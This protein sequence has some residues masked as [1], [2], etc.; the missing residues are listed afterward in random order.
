V[1]L[2]IIFSVPPPNGDHHLQGEA[3]KDRPR[4]T[5]GVKCRAN[6]I[7]AELLPPRCAAARQ[8]SVH[9][10]IRILPRAL[11]PMNLFTSKRVEKYIEFHFTWNVYINIRRLLP[12]EVKPSE[13]RGGETGEMGKRLQSSEQKKK[14]SI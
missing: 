9:F 7:T 6:L 12:K 11:P 8:I 4:L 10:Q 5:H 14:V 3:G 1:F 13:T 2:L